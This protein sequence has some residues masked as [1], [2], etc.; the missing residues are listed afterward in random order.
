M[1]LAAF[2]ARDRRRGPDPGTGRGHARRG[3]RTIEPVT[4][5][6][7][8]T[9]LTFDD[10]EDVAAAIRA[11]GGRL[12]ANRRLVLE[13]LFEAEGPVS[14][15]LLATPPRP[16]RARLRP[17][18]DLPQPRAARGTRRRATRAPRPR[19]RPL[20][21]RRRR[22]AGVPVLRALPAGDERGTR[23]SSTP[24]ARR[25]GSASATTRASATSRSRGF[26]AS[27]RP[28]QG[29]GPS[30]QTNTDTCPNTVTGI[31][32][33]RTGYPAPAGSSTSTSRSA[34]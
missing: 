4:S 2:V 26:V 34:Q 21:A 23:P 15:E 20:R 8:V 16:P 1:R 30:T 10:L 5:S 33:T 25:S 7:R 18:V 13:A 9:P 22:R 14:A 32:S 17:A 31:S 27:A 11:A 19:P 28:R 29:R 12:T 6:P 24:S 3:R